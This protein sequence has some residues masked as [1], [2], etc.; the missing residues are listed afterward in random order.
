MWGEAGPASPGRLPVVGLLVASVVVGVLAAAGRVGGATVLAVVALLV[1][2]ATVVSPAFVRW[3]G[4]AFQV[5][6]HGVGWVLLGATF[7]LVFV[8]VSALEGLLGR[9]LRPDAAAGAGEWTGRPSRPRRRATAPFARD[10]QARPGGWA[11]TALRL[12]GAVAALAVLDLA[13]GSVLITTG[14]VSGGPGDVLEQ[15][16]ALWRASMRTPAMAGEPWAEEYGE[17]L[18][19]LGLDTRARYE[20]FL[21]VAP[22]AFHTTY[23]NSDGTERRSWV[24]PL[25]P[26]TD[27]LQVAFFGGSTLFG[28]GQRDEHTIPSEFARLAAAAGVPVEVHNYGVAG[29]VSWQEMLYLER[30]LAH[31]HRYDL[32]VFYDGFNDVFVQRTDYRTDPTHNGIAILEELGR[33]YRRDHLDEPSLLDGVRSVGRSYLRWSAVANLTREVRG[34]EPDRNVFAQETSTATPAQQHAAALSIHQRAQE[35][36]DDL[37]GRSDTP[38]RWFWQAQQEPWAPDVLDN[39]PPD[40]TDLSGVFDGVDEPIFIDAAHTNELGAR[41]VAE[42]I[43]ED[44]RGEL[45]HGT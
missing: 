33:D 13:V 15:Q 43:W 38:V 4:R 31:G 30:L 2:H 32:I 18:I 34:D 1:A 6:A 8:P 12:G 19:A 36:V 22:E 27:A 45:T 39:L 23:L 24:P 16:T 41:L 10:R 25:P 20:P 40:V 42:A 29:W 21:F 14:I 28:I 3:T 7:A 11:A 37:A 17:E 35:L 44:V 26:G 9:P 5:V